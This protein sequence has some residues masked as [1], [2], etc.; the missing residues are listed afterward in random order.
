[1]SDVM[2]RVVFFVGGAGLA[3]TLMFAVFDLPEFGTFDGAFG[4]FLN[5]HAVSQRK[6]LNVVSSVNFDYR[7]LDTLGEEFILFAAVMGVALLMRAQREEEE[8][9]PRD[10]AQFRAAPHDS[11]AVREL[12]LGLV[13]P[14]VLF[15]LYVVAHGHLT[16]GGGFQG[17]V[18]LATAPL[19]MYLGGEYLALRRLSPETLVE[20]G[21]G[22]GAAGFVVVGALG[23]L[24]GVAFFEN[25]LPLGRVGDILSSGTILAG[26]IAV[27]LAVAA[28]FVL[29][30]SEF[31]EQTLEIRRGSQTR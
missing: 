9:P 12:C 15:G 14:T 29:L 26:N 23:L 19:L 28:G 3:V 11:D 5:D 4:L 18:T 6:G 8:L 27:G 13:A 17:G 2:R 30:L 31:L 7:A 16:P 1:V 21:E 20:L 10:Q 25:V 24:A 22:S